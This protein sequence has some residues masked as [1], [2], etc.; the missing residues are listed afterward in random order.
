MEFTQEE[1]RRYCG[2]FPHMKLSGKE[3]RGPC[4]VHKGKGPNFSVNLENGLCRCHS[5]CDKG[6]DLI[7]LEQD[8]HGSDFAKAL[9]QVCWI[10]GR[11]PESGKTIKPRPTRGK[12]DTTYDY[13]AEDGTLLFQAVRYKEPKGFNQRRPDGNGG[14]I[15]NLD[16]VRIV[17]YRLPAVMKADFVFIVEGE[18]DADTLAQLGQVATCN[19]MGAGKFRE[20]LAPYFA[21]KKVCI[22]PDND[23]PGKEHADKV[24]SALYGTAASIRILELPGMGEKG[25]VTDFIDAGH[26]LDDLRNLY[27]GA[28]VYDPDYCEDDQYVRTFRQEFDAAGGMNGFWDFTQQEGIP[29]PFPTLTRA[30]GGGMRDGEVY[31]IGGDTGGGKTS[32]GLQFG[33]TALRCDHGVLIFSMEMDHRAAMQRM[34][35]I[36]AKV[37]LNEFGEIQRALKRAMSARE[38]NSRVDGM[39]QEMIEMQRRLSLFTEEFLSYPLIVSR[40]SRV[41]PKYLVEETRRLKGKFPKIRMVIVDHMQLMSGDERKASEY[42]KFTAISRALKQAAVEMALP[43]IILSQTTRSHRHDGRFELELSDL[44]GSGAIEED[45]AGGILIYPDKKDFELAQTDGRLTKGPLK[46]WLKLAKS[47][48]GES[49]KYVPLM[50]LKFC[51]RFDLAASEA[52]A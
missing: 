36:E 42:E 23:K 44:R 16:G 38:R 2:Q 20:D 26:T 49:L 28:P 13:V 50:H 6:W 11:D 10:V 51:T 4:H 24:A 29:T 5:K 52:E 37:D 1:V 3:L 45:V 43:V 35:S 25:D 47:R 39:Y 46:S 19:P 40:K 30:L 8:L 33:I 48:F 14:F 32:M 22:I 7:G 41:T 34:V 9:E 12:L 21:G 18:K 27:R 31:C 15:Y 17:P